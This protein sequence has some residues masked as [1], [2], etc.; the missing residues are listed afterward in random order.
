[1]SPLECTRQFAS[2][3]CAQFRLTFYGAC[4]FEPEIGSGE[5]ETLWKMRLAADDCHMS[6]QMYFAILFDRFPP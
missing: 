6:Y 1:M 3:Y 2:D 5:F 4:H